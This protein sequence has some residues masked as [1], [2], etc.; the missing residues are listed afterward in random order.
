MTSMVGS[1][2]QKPIHDTLLAAGHLQRDV[3][4]EAAARVDHHRVRVAVRV[5]QV[6]DHRSAR[7]GGRIRHA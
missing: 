1:V 6:E 3:D 2:S 5:A 4:G 7:R